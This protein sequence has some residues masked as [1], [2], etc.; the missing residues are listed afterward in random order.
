MRTAPLLAAAIV[1]A[2]PAL[3]G[4]Y[5]QPYALVESGWRSAV[6]KE[7]PVSI[8][9]VDGESTLDRRRSAPITPG[10]HRID[11][12]LPLKAGA[13]TKKYRIVELDA[14]PCVRYR[15]VARYDNLTHVEWTPVVYSEPLGECEK[16]FGP[17]G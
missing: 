10:E 14:A 8:S 5:D 6:R 13:T 15:I 17:N 4:P 12:Y 1:V 9:R 2:M 3:A 16:K 7:L 11:V